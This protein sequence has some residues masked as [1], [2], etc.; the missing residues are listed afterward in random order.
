MFDIPYNNRSLGVTQLL[1][2]LNESWLAHEE[3]SLEPPQ[4]LGVMLVDHVSIKSSNLHT[5]ELREVDNRVERELPFSALMGNQSRATGLRA[6]VQRERRFI[7]S[8]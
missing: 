7:G 1:G 6:G 5:I 2:E 4:I 3:A 8:A